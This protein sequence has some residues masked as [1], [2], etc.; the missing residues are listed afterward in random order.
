MKLFGYEFIVR[1][2]QREQDH[3]LHRLLVEDKFRVTPLTPAQCETITSAF[4]KHYRNP[5]NR[6]HR[7]L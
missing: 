2:A 4:H 1:K 5:K 3:P 7:C 6:F